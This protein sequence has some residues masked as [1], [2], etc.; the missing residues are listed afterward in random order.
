MSPL[1]SESC[2]VNGQCD[3]V[4]DEGGARPATFG[5]Q[6]ML[7]DPC[8]SFLSEGRALRVQTRLHGSEL[9]AWLE[10]RRWGGA[11]VARHRGESIHTPQD[12]LGRSLSVSYRIALHVRG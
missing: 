12:R 1:C 3:K 6:N 4:G 11:V 10:R 5:S 7:A 8:P 2:S 9:P